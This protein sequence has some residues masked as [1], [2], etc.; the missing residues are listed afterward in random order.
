VPPKISGVPLANVCCGVS[1]LSG[2]DLLI[3][4]IFL[5]LEDGL[6]SI[7]NCALASQAAISQLCKLIADSLLLIE[8]ANP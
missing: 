5:T 2:T 1:I 7:L 4:E 8:L 6:G 3:E